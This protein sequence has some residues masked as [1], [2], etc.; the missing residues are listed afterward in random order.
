M[1]ITPA[2]A[3]HIVVISLGNR[4]ANLSLF[5][6]DLEVVGVRELSAGTLRISPAA[7]HLEQKFLSASK[8]SVWWQISQ[9]SGKD[10]VLIRNSVIDPS[11]SILSQSHKRKTT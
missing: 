3:N 11:R 9:R 2:I 7:S 1:G 5:S 8:Q 6:N 10:S 4:L